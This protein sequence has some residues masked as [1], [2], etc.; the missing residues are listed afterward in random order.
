MTSTKLLQIQR[1][2]GR[3]AAEGTTPLADRDDM[4]MDA[5]NE[6]ISRKA[7]AQIQAA[8]ERVEKAEKETAEVRK[9]LA[10]VQKELVQAHE[11]ANRKLEGLRESSKQEMEKMHRMH[12]EEMQRAKEEQVSLRKELAEECEAKARVEV[13]LEEA[14]KMQAHLEKM[15]AAAKVAS[16]APVVQT[17]SPVATPARGATATVTQRDQNGRIVSFTL[18][19]TT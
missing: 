3:S 19:P 5:V 10:A 7:G 12:M 15:L 2:L 9:Q 4:F 18:T 14:G 17:I 16:P 6:T 8:N 1:K 13:R 11:A